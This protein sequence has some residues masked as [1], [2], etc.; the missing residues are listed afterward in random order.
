[1]SKLRL[2]MIAGVCAVLFPTLAGAGGTG[3]C[4]AF[5]IA[6][7]AR[8]T[9]LLP[10]GDELGFALCI[11]NLTEGQC[12]QLV[13]TDLWLE[14]ESCLALK[15]PFPAWDGACTVS[16]VPDFGEVCFLLW[17][18]PQQT[19]TSQELCA[20]KGQGAWSDDPSSCGAPVPATPRAAL[21]LMILV[22]L[23]GSL[24]LLAARTS[25]A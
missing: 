11:D 7:D 1:M 5:D 10:R 18:D 20:D 4:V 21:A 19:F 16:N 6:A 22:L 23:A 3:A 17:T 8:S 25:S 24:S 13:Q 2:L 14:G 9:P 15:L 12:D